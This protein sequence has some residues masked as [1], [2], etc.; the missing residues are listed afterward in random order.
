MDDHVRKPTLP[1]TLVLDEGLR[2]TLI[3]A[4]DS[5]GMA[6][7][8]PLE[9]S[10]AVLRHLSMSPRLS[11]RCRTQDTASGGRRWARPGIR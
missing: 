1:S 2:G 11:S 10:W 7:E 8:R 9:I 5:L 4:N 6:H 3:T